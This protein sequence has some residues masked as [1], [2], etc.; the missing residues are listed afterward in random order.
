[1]AFNFSNMTI[2][3]HPKMEYKNKKFMAKGVSNNKKKKTT[4]SKLK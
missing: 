3:K 1:M 4:C 2:L